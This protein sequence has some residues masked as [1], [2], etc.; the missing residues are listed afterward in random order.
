MEHRATYRHS[1]IKYSKISLKVR[2]KLS[3]EEAAACSG[4]FGER[5]AFV[6]DG[7][8]TAYQ[9]FDGQTDSQK[10]Q[11]RRDLL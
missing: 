1:N 8:E 11:I 6:Q 7:Q 3:L 9:P 5:G 10:V 2:N 4:S